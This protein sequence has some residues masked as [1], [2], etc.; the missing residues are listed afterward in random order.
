MKRRYLKA[1]DRKTRGYY[2]SQ[3]THDKVAEVAAAV[4]CSISEYVEY[5]LDTFIG[6]D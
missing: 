1:T 3:R 4:P 5:A 6:E 2:I